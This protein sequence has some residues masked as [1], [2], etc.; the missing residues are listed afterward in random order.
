MNMTKALNAPGSEEIMTIEEH[1]KSSE[2]Y[3]N[4]NSPITFDYKLNDK[5][6]RSKL[7][8]AAKRTP[9]EVDENSTSTNLVYSAGAWY[10]VV[11]PSIKYFEEAKGEKTCKVGEY[12]V[13]VGG[14]R[15]GKE[16]NGKHVNTQIVFFLVI[17]TKLSAISTTLH[18]SS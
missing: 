1:V 14:I 7:L 15:L 18:S 16:S 3:K 5:A 17:E 13:R 6:S 2:V 10:H 9:L 11:L 12:S 4:M 8:K